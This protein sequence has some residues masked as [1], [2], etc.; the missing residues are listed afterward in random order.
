MLPIPL[1]DKIRSLINCHKL[2][3]S[4]GSLHMK[5]PIKIN[6]LGNVFFLKVNNG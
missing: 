1:E 2:G 6:L 3:Q 5:Y 4:T